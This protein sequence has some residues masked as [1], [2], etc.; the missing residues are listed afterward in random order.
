MKRTICLAMCA[1]LPLTAVRAEE[2]K[3]PAELTDPVEILKRMDEAAKVVKTVAYD[4]EF[5]ATGDATK[6][7]A[8]GKGSAILK[9]WTG[10]LPEKYRLDVEIR[11]EG[12]ESRRVSAGA[13]GEHYYLID[14]STKT[15][16]EDI[17][18]AVM[19]SASSV[20]ITAVVAEFVHP[21]P[22]DDEINAKTHE[23]KGIETVA[24]VECYVVAVEY[25]IG[26]K[27]TWFV[28]KNDFLPRRRI[29]H[30]D[31]SGLGKG[32]VRKTITRLVVDPNLE[33][34]AFKLK[35]PEG[36]TKTD[37]FAP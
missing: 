24:G 6:F 8:S 10:R 22:F 30:F 14:H 5:E 16:H 21:K 25:Q 33:E 18:P 2:E 35:L 7:V 4:I 26:R 15:A 29:D 1:L 27:A 20:L 31:D 3:Q 13:D 37:D 19:G 17:D 12:A 36:F 32:D 23:F 28:G 11:K 9:G 34:D